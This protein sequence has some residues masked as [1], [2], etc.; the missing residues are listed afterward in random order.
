MMD[1]ANEYAVLQAG[2]GEAGQKMLAQNHRLLRG[3]SSMIGWAVARNEPASQE[4]MFRKSASGIHCFL[5]PAPRWQ[6][7]SPAVML[8]SEP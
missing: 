8:S 2:T 6:S 3:G 5:S 7:Q 4:T 1:D